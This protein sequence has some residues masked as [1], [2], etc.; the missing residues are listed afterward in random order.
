ME[1]GGGGGGEGGTNVPKKIVFFSLQEEE[2]NVPHVCPSDW[3]CEEGRF[4]DYAEKAKMV[5]FKE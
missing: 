3:H 4:A 1:G 2:E 5:C